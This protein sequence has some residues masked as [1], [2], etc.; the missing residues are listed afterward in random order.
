M[1]SS[2]RAQQKKPNAP[3]ECCF[4]SYCTRPSPHLPL[5]PW[6]AVTHLL[7]SLLLHLKVWRERH[8]GGVVVVGKPK[9]KQEKCCCEVLQNTSNGNQTPTFLNR[10]V[11]RWA[12]VVCNVT[13]QLSFGSGSRKRKGRNIGATKHNTL[14]QQLQKHSSSNQ[15][16]LVAVVLLKRGRDGVHPVVCSGNVPASGCLW[17]HCHWASNRGE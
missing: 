16:P 13:N 17:H 15:V 4:H 6:E 8:G 1:V 9:P 11:R 14:H 12:C 10:K 3:N 7:G 5:S 2:C